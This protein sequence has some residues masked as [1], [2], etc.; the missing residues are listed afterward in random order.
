[1]KKT[2]WAAALLCAALNAPHA[3]AQGEIE[4]ATTAIIAPQPSD[5]LFGRLAGNFEINAGAPANDA[6]AARFLTQATFGPTIIDMGEL[7][8]IGYSAWIERQLGLVTT[9]QR[10]EVEASIAPSAVAMPRNGPFYRPF[11]IERWFDSTVYGSD[12]LRQRVAFALSQ[13]MVVSDIG[14]L[15]ASPVVVAEYNDILLRNA[16]GN[17]RDLLREVTYSP[18]M[19]AY[20]THLRNRKTDWTLVNNVLTPALIQPDENYAREIMQ[21][22]SI[23]LVERNR[24]F[25]PILLNGNPV[26]TYNQDLISQTARAFTGLGYSCSGNAVVAGVAINRNCGA[27]V[28]ADCNFSNT[29]FFANPPRYVG[30]MQPNLM[31]TA[32]VHPDGYRPLVCYPRYADTG[33]SATGANNYAV[34][35]APN[36][37]K[38]LLNG[39]V[40]PPSTVACHTATPGVDRQACINYCTNQIDTVVQSLFAH[41]NAAPMVARQLIQRLTTSTPDA[42]YIDRVA[43]QFENDGTGVRGNLA[44]VVRQVL[45]DPD[46]RSL[47]PDVNFG[48]VRE[49][50]L[51]L[52][53]IWRAFNAQKG[54]AGVLNLPAPENFF[55]QRPLGAQTVFNF[56]EP[57]YAQPGEI[58][59]AGLYSPELQIL[60]ESTAITAADELW[61]RVFSGYA[62]S[63][64]TITNYQQPANSASLPAT[65]I[66]ALPADS[67]G[68]V[69]EISKRMLFG[70]M[71]AVTRGKLITL[72]NTDLA[73]TDKRRKALNLI[74]LV[75]IS[76]EFAVQR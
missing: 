13:M 14:A 36:A 45:L 63:G 26:Q 10:P 21:L 37:N 68:L 53:A 4:D 56:Y 18:A 58:Q 11:R 61:R 67:P 60:N 5:I 28:G 52:T 74:H 27:C 49:P 30:G 20:L 59:D 71:S 24:D 23:G 76:P 9:L 31:V 51:R 66:D 25:S 64:T 34:L 2:I 3:L 16:F 22:F 48:K 41:P 42:D 40:V 62:F 70:E 47:T 1:M 15:D 7:K 17:Y 33:R 50:L 72:L 29:L 35:P 75:A 8:S 54:T 69:D 39:I 12:Q 32:L 43:A 38:L 6:Q 55:A 65:E 44:A 19:G 57:D 46:A 73:T